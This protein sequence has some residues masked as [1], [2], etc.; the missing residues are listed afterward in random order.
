MGR[1]VHKKGI[2][3]LE[4]T[5]ALT[6]NRGSLLPSFPPPLEVRSLLTDFREVEEIPLSLDMDGSIT[7]LEKPAA[8]PSYRLSGTDAVWEGPLSTLAQRA[9]DLRFSLWGNQGFLYRFALF[10]LEVKHRIYNLH[11]CSLY[12]AD[13]NR[14]F[15]IAGGAGS[16]KTVYLLSGLLQGLALFST[17]TIHFRSE[18]RHIRWFMGSLVDNV[19][20]GTLKRYFPRFL[21]LARKAMT[22]PKWQDKRAIDLSGYRCQ[23]DEL[24]DPKVVLLFPRIEE[25]FDSLALEPIEDVRKTAHAL[26]ANITEKIAETIILYDQIPQ[27]GL[28]RPDLAK[29]RLRAAQSL[30]R[31]RNTVFTSAVLTSPHRPW[32]DLLERDF[33][34][35]RRR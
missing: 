5:I 33:Q 30:A 35:R 10:L 20:L 14:L 25:G 22:E 12:Q 13:K 15:V 29:A 6:S 24:V 17:E 3:I 27:L 19:R 26:F 9:S 21:P 1:T 7:I 34:R 28:D 4:A 2:R 8:A 18:G 23:H 32:G 31:H 11:A 16:G